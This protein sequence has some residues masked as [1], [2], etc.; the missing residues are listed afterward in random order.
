MSA[1]FDGTIDFLV[2][3]EEVVDRPPDLLEATDCLPEPKDWRP[4]VPK[5][6]DCLKKF[7][8]SVGTKFSQTHP[9]SR[10][11]TSPSPPP[12]HTH[13]HREAWLIKILKLIIN[14]LS[15]NMEFFKKLFEKSL[16][17]NRPTFSEYFLA[18][19][20]DPG[21][22][23]K[24]QHVDKRSKQLSYLYKKRYNDMNKV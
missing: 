15:D 21:T 4:N 16:V 23:I 19:G 22:L 9:K 8:R 1:R 20:F 17:K 12:P 11:R 10:E 2:G 18:A 6:E 13:T 3:S 24:I 5:A 7:D 14:F